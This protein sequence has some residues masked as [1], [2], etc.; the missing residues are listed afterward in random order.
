MD[1]TVFPNYESG[2]QDRKKYIKWEETEEIRK[3]R[4]VGRKERERGR[5]KRE[6]Q[7]GKL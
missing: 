2:I 1:G 7:G 4:E 3:E 6:K 5:R